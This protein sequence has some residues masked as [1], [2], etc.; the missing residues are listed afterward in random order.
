[1]ATKQDTLKRWSKL[2]TR[3][4]PRQHAK[5]DCEAIGVSHA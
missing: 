4:N 3:P 1:M 2:S 5:L